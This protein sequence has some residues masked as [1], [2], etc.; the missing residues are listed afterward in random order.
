M[1]LLRNNRLINRSGTSHTYEE[2][3]NLFGGP[4]TRLTIL[5]FKIYNTN[6]I[7]W[8]YI[9]ISKNLAFNLSK[10]VIY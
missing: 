1:N 3:E 9:T 5:E 8:L 6:E 10:W 7:N 2:I 4:Y